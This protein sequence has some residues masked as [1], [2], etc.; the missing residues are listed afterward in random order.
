MLVW[1]RLDAKKKFWGIHMDIK[2]LSDQA[3]WDL[4]KSKVQTER[5]VTLEIIELLREVRSRR[6]H[7]ERKYESFH[8]Y[9][10]KEL[11]YDDGSAH[12]RIKALDLAT[13][14]PEVVQCIQKGTLSLTTASQVQSFFEQ[15]AKKDKAFSKEEKLVLLT[16]LESKSKREIEKTLATLAPETLK[17]TE[18]VKYVSGTHL[19]LELVIDEA[20][21][22]KME[23]LRDLTSHT[24]STMRDL[25]E[26]L[27]DEA[28][29]KKD[30]ELKADVTS[31]GKCKKSNT[32]Q[33]MGQRINRPSN[34]RYIPADIKRRVWVE[35]GS[36]CTFVNPASGERCEAKRFL[37]IEHVVPFA[38]GGK[39]NLENLTL[40][41]SNHN[42]LKAIHTFG[43]STMDR[44]LAT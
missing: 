32:K 41:C 40:L 22:K 29:K 31:P 30:P 43:K 1:P 28:L 12:R 18:K 13:Q 6:L 37:Q 44:Y 24:N 10:V 21:M 4:T 20:L 3:L 25:I 8:Q 16:D 33:D 2:Q 11:K 36:R 27:V 19:K 7:L 42:K 38:L 35:A 17:H 9:C 23:R 34:S 26:S 15:E 5:N 14:I 39:S